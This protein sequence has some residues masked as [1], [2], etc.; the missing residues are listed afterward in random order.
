MNNNDDDRP[1]CINDPCICLC[2]PCLLIFTCFE[3]CCKYACMLVCC[4]APE[5]RIQANKIYVNND[6]D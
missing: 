4:I 5:N 2:S 1:F 3:N 6:N